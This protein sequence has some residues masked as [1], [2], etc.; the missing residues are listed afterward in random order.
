M[1]LQNA[2]TPDRLRADA[3]RI[4]AN[5][6]ELLRR[7]QGEADNLIRDAHARADAMRRTARDYRAIADREDAEQAPSR[8]R[9]CSAPIVRDSLGWKHLADTACPVAEPVEPAPAGQPV[10]TG[11]TYPLET[12]PMPVAG[13][14]P[15]PA[16][17]AP[18]PIAVDQTEGAE[19]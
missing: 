6:E 16:P 9:T 13:Q 18:Q 14:A 2:G 11:G 19:Q 4:E 1:E 7:A 15:P 17:T 5:A 3:D 10:A 8:C 12:A